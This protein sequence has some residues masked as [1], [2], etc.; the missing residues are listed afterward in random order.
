MPL[1]VPDLDAKFELKIGE[2]NEQVTFII[3]PL[4]YPEKQII[5]SVST[6]MRSGELHIDGSSIA[7]YSL[8]YALVDVKGLI[9]ADG[10]EW[11]LKRE[12]G[13]DYNT[14]ECIDQLMNT[15]V[16]EA[17]IYAG[18]KLMSGIPKEILDPATGKPLEG[19]EIIPQKSNVK[20]N[21]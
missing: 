11:K 9:D 20:K 12:E 6:S 7:F 4:K 18:S 13:K 5:T 1:V 3:R 19:C 2:G 17:L 16:N 14:D 15:P 10:N 8:K 21:S